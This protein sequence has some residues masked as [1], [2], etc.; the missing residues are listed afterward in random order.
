[1]LKKVV[2]LLIL[3]F[4]ISFSFCGCGDDQKVSAS[5]PND[6]QTEQPSEPPLNH[7]EL[8]TN[9]STEPSVLH[10][11]WKIAYYSNDNNS[12]LDYSK[13][14]SE[15]GYIAFYEDGEAVIQF[16]QTDVLTCQYEPMAEK[17]SISLYSTQSGD[18]IGFNFGYSG[19]Y[20]GEK[21]FLLLS[22]Y[23]ITDRSIIYY[24]LREVE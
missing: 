11:V 3:C 4:I 1:M 14:I 18:P 22:K 13:D 15:N 10:G 9:Y 8:G 5:L 2:S 24:I 7:L 16:S 19:F 20:V 6:T 17:S 23:N 12:Y 21:R